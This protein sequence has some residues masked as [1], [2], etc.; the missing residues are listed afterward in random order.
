MIVDDAEEEVDMATDPFLEAG[1]EIPKELPYQTPALQRKRNGSIFGSSIFKTNEHGD[2]LS[3]ASSVVSLAK[4]TANNM[5]NTKPM[6]SF[7]KHFRPNSNTKYSKVKRSCS[8]PKNVNLISQNK[9][10]KVEIPPHFY[11]L[12]STAPVPGSDKNDG[13]FLFPDPAKAKSTTTIALVNENICTDENVDE[14]TENLLPTKENDLKD[15]LKMSSSSPR[16]PQNLLKCTIEEEEEGE[17]DENN[18]DD[19]ELG[20]MGKGKTN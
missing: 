19:P 7:K 20:D 16:L 8:S 12:S 18:G 2:N 13:Q 10:L 4:A 17:S 9:A 5:V 15:Q 1:I 6:R 3:R 14:L 11:D